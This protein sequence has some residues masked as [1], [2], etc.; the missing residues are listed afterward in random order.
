M[1]IEGKSTSL[2]RFHPYGMNFSRQVSDSHPPPPNLVMQL[3][4]FQETFLVCI[5]YLI[6]LMVFNNF[7]LNKNRPNKRLQRNKKRIWFSIVM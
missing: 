1:Y 2:F 6:L 5:Y 7:F 3:L 4:I